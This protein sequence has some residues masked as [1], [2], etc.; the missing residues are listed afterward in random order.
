MWEK[1]LREF[2]GSCCEEEW[3]LRESWRRMS[4]WDGPLGR[5]LA[6]VERADDEE[7]RSWNSLYRLLSLSSGLALR[8]IPCR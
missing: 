4:V 1:A 3:F 2:K 6:V 8:F 5:E 7:G